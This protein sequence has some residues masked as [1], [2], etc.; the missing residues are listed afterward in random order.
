MSEEFDPNGSSVPA[1]RHDA[2][3]RI[4]ADQ[5]RRQMFVRGLTGADL[6]HRSGTSQ[7]TISH[8]LNGRRVSPRTLRGICS[9]LSHIEPIAG[10][11]ILLAEGAVDNP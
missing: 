5:L 4:R 7:A 11:D 9:A 10:A 6:A 8:C 1:S 2:G 3:V